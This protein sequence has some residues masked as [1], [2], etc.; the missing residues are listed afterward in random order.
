MSTDELPLD[1][2]TTGWTHQLRK[3]S[4]QLS[5]TIDGETYRTRFQATIEAAVEDARFLARNCELIPHV[6]QLEMPL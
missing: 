3:G 6:E 4:H 5:I 2:R 1:L